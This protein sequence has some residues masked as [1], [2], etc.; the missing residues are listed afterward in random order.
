MLADGSNINTDP[1]DELDTMVDDNLTSLEQEKINANESVLTFAFK[2][3]LAMPKQKTDFLKELLNLAHVVLF[4]RRSYD[5]LTT[6]QLLP[7]NLMRCHRFPSSNNSVK[8][9]G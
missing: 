2:R 8:A 7:I 1:D 4:Q 3:M 6:N 5:G 9:M